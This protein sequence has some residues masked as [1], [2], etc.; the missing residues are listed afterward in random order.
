MCF[1][2]KTG[3]YGLQLELASSRRI[4]DWFFSCGRP[5]RWQEGPFLS[6]PPLTTL[7]CRVP[8]PR[9][10]PKGKGKGKAS[11]RVEV[12]PHT[13]SLSGSRPWDRWIVEEKSANASE[14]DWK[15]GE[16][17]RER[18]R[19]RVKRVVW[20]H[21]ASPPE[22]KTPPRVAAARRRPHPGLSLIRD[23]TL[24]L[25]GGMVVRAGSSD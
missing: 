11:Q 5:S 24:F 8:H 23:N 7:P 17:E 2:E 19:V 20:R 3:K 18:E 25:G 14:S 15:R 12:W 16:R 1:V 22:R 21:A 13:L 10:R 6:P 9:P 4:L